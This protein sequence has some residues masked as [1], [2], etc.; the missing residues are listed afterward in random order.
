MAKYWSVP[1]LVIIATAGCVVIPRTGIRPPLPEGV[2][3]LT[4]QA[5]ERQGKDW[6]LHCGGSRGWAWRD[7]TGS[8]VKARQILVTLVPATSPVRD[9][10]KVGDV[11]LGV[12][13]KYFTD[14][15]IYQF[16]DASKP[17]QSSQGRFQIILWREGWDKERRVT[18]DLS[19]NPLDFTKGDKPGRETDWNLGPTGARGWMQDRFKESFAARQIYVTDVEKGSP[20]DGILQEG[21]VILGIG[22][23]K[24]R[25]D[26]RKTFGQA[27]T[28]A[29]TQQGN[30]KLKLLRW[31]ADK[32]ETVTIHIPVMGSYSNTTPWNCE[33][34]RRILEQ[35]L[36][37]VI[38]NKILERK[39][40]MHGES[41]IGALALMS[42]GDEEHMAHAKIH[43][44][45]L[46]ALVEKS[47]EY[48]P[49]WGY[50]AWG[51]GYGNLIVT[52]YYLLTGDKRALPA[53]R[54]FSERLAVGQSGAGSW[55][56]SM[57]WSN[58]GPCHGYG[59]LN[60]AGNVCLMSLVLAQQCGVTSPEIE[61]AVRE[62]SA[63]LNQFVDIQPIPYGDHIGIDPGGHDDNG[64]ASQGAVIFALSGEEKAADFYT[65]MTIAS[66]AV[67]E[68]G[69]T[70]NW[71][72]TL[73][74]PLGA[75]RA[76][77]PGCSAFLH[78][79]TWYHDLERRWDGGFTYQGKMG[80]GYGID[81]KT[82]QQ[83]GGSEHQY[84][85]WDTTVCRILMYALP[86]QRL[87]VTGKNIGTLDFSEQDVTMLIAAGQ[88][89]PRDD[90]TFGQTYD[91]RR[92]S[93]LLELLGHWS[94]V[95]RNFA[96]G[97][98]AKK[99]GDHVPA[100]LAMLENDSR[101]ARYGACTG[102]RKMGA[103][104][105]PALDA[106]LDK[107]EAEDPLL[108]IHAAMALGAIGD[109]RAVTPMLEMMAGEIES[110]P[111]DLVR[112]FGSRA[113]FARGGLLH[114][115]IDG[116]D[117]ELLFA[118]SR[119]LLECK[120]G[121]TRSYVASAVLNK[122]TDE[123][124]KA[125]WPAAIPALRKVAPTE[126]MFASGIRESVAKQLVDGNIVE[127]IPLI[128]EYMK[129]Q[130]PHGSGGRIPRIA[131]MLKKYGASAQ[132]Y[133]PQM[134]E[135]LAFLEQEH[136]HTDKG[137][138]AVGGF[139]KRQIPHMKEVIETIRNA[140]DGP[141]L[142]SIKEHLEAR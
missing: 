127:G 136:P 27:I 7:E 37:Y 87:V 73:W 115:S 92:V 53:I 102:L 10:L 124:R 96:S 80:F 28:Q 133:L 82:G 84:G 120:G 138:P 89:P 121:A 85:H 116:V 44:D 93:E 141:E 64:K 71:F 72:S 54:K 32:A 122:L 69:H 107:L 48:P 118:A 108:R 55:G 137:Q 17:A 12:N 75:A 95:V 76:G 65:R 81:E 106:L 91:G 128:L 24:F 59:A 126:I 79:L 18:L 134:E 131:D 2:P 42:T 109:R 86:Q 74:G 5:V 15:P 140:K 104:A 98:L 129:H 45:K 41:M 43:V 61:R 113:L 22:G 63:F 35:A 60:Q 31:R 110:D 94:P 58:H 130:K 66:H 123:E 11:I 117:R 50:P 101:F 3:D 142:I 46:L 29:E 112:R 57:A 139:Y 114:A 56:H 62:G 47:G 38:R 132:P 97:S 4:E 1:A 6:Y 34:S 52:E 23:R 70:G 13:G 21:D 8:C 16:R 40:V 78:E 99:R 88:R 39:G 51:W 19:Y 111:R 20:A 26:A 25:T 36:D 103:A 30:G 33:K 67:R 9:E 125:M 119:R 68:R 90:Q 100:L 83:K 105:A 14:Q 135:Y 49:K 77:Q